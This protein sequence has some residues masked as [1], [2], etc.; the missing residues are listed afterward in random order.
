MRAS[1]DWSY[2]LLS[3]P[4]QRLCDRLSV[5]A[6]GCTLAAAEA[7]CA[8]A[9]IGGDDVLGPL[10]SLVEKS[11]I[12]ADFGGREPR[13]RLF[14]SFRE[15]GREKLAA[16]GELQIMAQCHALACL[17]HAQRL[18]RAHDNEGEAVW[19]ALVQEELNNCREALQWALAGGGTLFEA[20]LGQ[21]QG[22]KEDTTVRRYE[23]LI[24]LYLKPKFGDVQAKHLK[25]HHLMTAYT[26]WLRQGREGR[27][28]SARTIRHA[29]ELLRNVLNWGV[30][31]ELL[32]RNIAALVGDD[33]LPKAVKPKP[34]ALTDGEVR[35]LLQEAR[36]PTRR[37]KKRGTLSSQLWFYPAVAFSVYTGARRGE[38]VALR[39]TDVNL[40]KKSV[41][42]ARSLTER[43]TFK[44]PKSDRERT[45]IVSDR[46][47]RY[48]APTS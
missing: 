40:E 8:H 10:S 12:A 43:M 34:L 45:I 48:S 21:K 19:H 31:R 38:V 23:T 41:T 6:G 39:W 27:V 15:Y 29:H 28:V 32:S 30:R 9:D 33:D 2:E 13:Y 42:I 16:R 7:V 14:E 11:M 4:E 44:A 1:I 5:F 24:G 25:L 26:E 37:A 17:E 35:K 47:A 36:D 46:S 18:D 22:Q 3:T 20:F